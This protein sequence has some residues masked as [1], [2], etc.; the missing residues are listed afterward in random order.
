MDH[1]FYNPCIQD[2]DQF[3]NWDHSSSSFLPPNLDHQFTY[4]DHRG[5]NGGS[6]GG[7]SSGGGGGLEDGK[8]TSASKNHSEAEKRRRDRINAHL[9]TLRKLVSNSDKMDKATLLGKVVEHVKELKS[10]TKELSKVSTIPTDLDEV[11]IDLDSNARGPNTN[12]FI[13]ASLCCEDRQEV[14]SEIKHALKSL[15]L[16]MVQADMTCLGGRIK[17]NLILCITN[18]NASKID[19]KELMTLKHS[20]KILFGRIVASSS[21][22]TST[23]YRIKSKRQRFFCSSNYDTHECQ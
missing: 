15:R 3:S 20:L 23:N 22:T 14:F 18:N 9:N 1:H 2:F 8:A 17:C 11:I 21:W 7:G 16:T 13:R 5:G 19:E 4:S 10:E 12:V 6:S